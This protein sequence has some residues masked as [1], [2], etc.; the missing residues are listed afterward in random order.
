MKIWVPKAMELLA[1]GLEEPR[2]EL[3]E[4]DW[5]S[6]LSPDKKRLSEHLCAFGN[7][8]GG[9]YLAFGVNDNGSVCGVGNAEVQTIVL[10]LGNLSRSALEPEIAIDYSVEDFD[11]ANS[12]VP[13]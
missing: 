11:C 5:K 13:G 3:N 8:P 6:L 7:L 10:Q 12:R 1:A 9:G 2:H 4:L